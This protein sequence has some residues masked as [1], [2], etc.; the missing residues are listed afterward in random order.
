[1]KYKGAEEIANS[2]S[3][4]MYTRII[5]VIWCFIGF[6]AFTPQIWTFMF[7]MPLSL[8]LLNY[9]TEYFYSVIIFFQSVLF[10]H[11]LKN[12]YFC[13]FNMQSI[14]A[15]CYIYVTT[16]YAKLIFFKVLFILLFL[17]LHWFWWGQVVMDVQGLSLA[18]ASGM[19][20]FTTLHSLPIVMFLL[21][22]NTGSSFGTWAPELCPMSLVTLQHVGSSQT[23]IVG[24]LTIN[25]WISRVVLNKR[26][27]Y[28][29][30]VWYRTY[31]SQEVL[32]K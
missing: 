2:L 11:V 12:K 16:L 32:L 13:A 7:G 23:R 10:Y 17:K 15:C 1:M 9:C 4:C 19:V 8:I 6:Y 30:E 29:L 21:L 18:E 24:K 31:E 5:W 20:H 3:R 22:E 25:R 26:R 28:R 14:F 27:R